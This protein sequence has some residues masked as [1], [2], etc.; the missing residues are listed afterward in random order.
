M[1]QNRAYGEMYLQDYMLGEKV[2]KEAFYFEQGKK[3]IVV[4]NIVS[5]HTFEFKHKE[6]CLLYFKSKEDLK[7]IKA[8]I[9]FT[10]NL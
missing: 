6:S 9:K 7:E 10:R 5:F 4:D 8:E 1:E 3:W 2:P